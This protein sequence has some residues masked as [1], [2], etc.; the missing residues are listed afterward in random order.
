MYAALNALQQWSAPKYSL[1]R[2]CYTHTPLRL[3]TSFAKE[4]LYSRALSCF[5]NEVHISKEIEGGGGAP[6][7]VENF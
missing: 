1:S 4:G 3:V 7:T 2:A 5:L 6:C